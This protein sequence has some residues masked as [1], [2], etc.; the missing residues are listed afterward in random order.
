M[1]DRGYEQDGETITT[2]GFGIPMWLEGT[3]PD[4]IGTFVCQPASRDEIE[5]YKDELST[6]LDSIGSGNRVMLPTPSW[7]V[8][9]DPDGIGSSSIKPLSA[10]EAITYGTRYFTSL[11]LN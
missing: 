7:V 6:A 2:E 3:D 10:N 9:K 8:Y 5:A 1:G 4:S 11:K